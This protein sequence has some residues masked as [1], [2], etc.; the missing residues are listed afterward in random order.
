[1]EL[2]STKQGRV[3]WEEDRPAL[4]ETI[5]KE[6]KTGMGSR[7]DQFIEKAEGAGQK[8]EGAG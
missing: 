1:M 3:V 8:R 4:R 5:E 2:R 7:W 6:D